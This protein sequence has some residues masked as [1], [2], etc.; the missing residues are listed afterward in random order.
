M[1]GAQL[2]QLSYPTSYIPT[3]GSTATRL[4]ETANNAGGAGVFN[5]EE[6]VLY[7]EIAALNNSSGR[8]IALSNGTTNERLSIAFQGNDIRLYIRKHKWFDMGLYLYKCKHI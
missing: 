2:E 5:S 6:G 8:W 3:S 1:W 4:G 7:A